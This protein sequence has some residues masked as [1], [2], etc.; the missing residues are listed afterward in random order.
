MHT[1]VKK[2]VILFIFIINT[3]V[4]SISL[5]VLINNT[6]EMKSEGTFFYTE[7]RLHWHCGIFMIIFRQN[8]HIK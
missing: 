1:A 2:T 8:Y 5:I 7:R 4:I 3:L 6:A